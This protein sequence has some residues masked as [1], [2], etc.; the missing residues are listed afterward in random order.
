M[1]TVRAKSRTICVMNI[2][3][4][5]EYCLSLP[6]ASEYFPFDESVLAFRVMDKIFAMID[7]ADTEWF[8]L[9]CDPELALELREEHP[10]ING[11]W[12][13]NKKYW[14]QVSIFGSLSDSLIKSLIRHSY[15]E[16]VKKFTNKAKSGHPE[17]LTI[18]KDS[19]T[20]H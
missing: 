14:N 2:E 11:A 5:R 10:E 7:L 6:L 4:L 3:D 20:T 15:S 1:H 16:V 18:T 8:V 9:K 17:I 13:M 12:H 19:D